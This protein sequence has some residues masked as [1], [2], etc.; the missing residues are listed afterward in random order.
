VARRAA[1]AIGSVFASLLAPAAALLVLVVAVVAVAAAAHSGIQAPG[2]PPGVGLLSPVGGIGPTGSD[3]AGTA[4][5]LLI[6]ALI[7][8]VTLFLIVLLVVFLWR[9]RRQADPARTAAHESLGAR[10]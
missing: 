1:E 7:Q 9:R 2:G 6:G 4:L 10:R 3:P 8:S 5:R